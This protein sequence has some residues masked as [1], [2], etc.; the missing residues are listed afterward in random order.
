MVLLAV[1]DIL[2]K[3][4]GV[5]FVG[6]GGGD[7]RAGKPAAVVDVYDIF[8]K[9]IQGRCQVK[10]RAQIIFQRFIYIRNRKVYIGSLGK[11]LRM[12]VERDPSCSSGER[13]AEGFVL[14]P[15]KRAGS[16]FA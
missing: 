7:I 2:V 1:E 15:L 10:G 12:A 14:R 6:E 11:S 8:C 13:F 5:S 4:S 9:C 16:F 3:V